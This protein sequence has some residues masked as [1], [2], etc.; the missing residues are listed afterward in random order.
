MDIAT[1]RAI[2]QTE[3][4]ER[5][6]RLPGEWETMRNEF[7]DSAARIDKNKLHEVFNE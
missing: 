4:R 1:E 7:V 3:K 6:S 5:R 2:R